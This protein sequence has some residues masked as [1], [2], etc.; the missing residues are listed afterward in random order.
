MVGCSVGLTTQIH[1]KGVTY[2]LPKTLVK[3][4]VHRVEDTDT[5]RAWYE[6]GNEQGEFKVESAPDLEH[7]YVL[8][9]H[10]SGMHDDRLCITRSRTGLLNDV[11]F[12]SDDRTPEV[13]FNVT[14]F[15]AGLIG[16]PTSAPVVGRTAAV[17]NKIVVRS[18]VAQID[19]FDDLSVGAF[20]A[21]LSRMF[22]PTKIQID[23]THMRRTLSVL[24]ARAPEPRCEEPFVCYRTMVKVP[25]Y[26]VQ[27][28]VP[29]GA[30]YTEVANKWDIGQIDVTRAFLVHKITKLRFDNGALTAA[31]VRKP[32]EVEE[33]SL[34]PLTIAN[35]ILSVPAGVFNRA[36]SAG[37]DRAALLTEMNSLKTEVEKLAAT[38]NLVL[39][40]SGLNTSADAT[41]YAL[42]C[43]AGPREGSFVDITTNAALN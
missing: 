43:E 2:Y 25:I 1:D 42:N 26:L 30:V 11:Q 3:V 5:K 15:I 9:Y 10:P 22:A 23:L 27:N 14:R 39:Q 34:L 4:E 17:D 21:G 12:A 29:I 38:Q 32:S 19:P 28:G 36:F 35:A 31:M 20:N 37:A 6:F 24:K 13:A 7:H 33:V 18:Y 8:K 40:G 16:S 41:K